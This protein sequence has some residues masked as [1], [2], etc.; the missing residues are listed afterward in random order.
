MQEIFNVDLNIIFI[1][2]NILIL[3][4]NDF[5]KYYNSSALIHWAT[6]PCKFF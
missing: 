4:K 6:P 1:D 3:N 5:F 2:F